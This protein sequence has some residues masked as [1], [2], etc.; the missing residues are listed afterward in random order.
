MAGIPGVRNISDDII[1]YGKTKEAH[2][3]ALQ[4]T[5]ERLKEN[6]LTI[7]QKCLFDQSE[8]GFFGYVF[9]GKGLSPDPTIVEALRKAYQP[10][11]AAEVRSF[12]GMANSEWQMQ[13]YACTWL[14]HVSRS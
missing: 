8:I 11:N 2:N 12:L 6:G 14:S 9:S 4:H 5:F 10:T 3:Q 1:V 13:G 7:K